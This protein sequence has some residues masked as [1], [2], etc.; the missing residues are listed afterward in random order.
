MFQRA[1]QLGCDMTEEFLRPEAQSLSES[2]RIGDIVRTVLLAE[3]WVPEHIV[4][5]RPIRRRLFCI[6]ILPSY[7]LESFLV[8]LLLLPPS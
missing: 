4:L 3:V 5:S 2:L 8:S 7:I 1:T 6:S